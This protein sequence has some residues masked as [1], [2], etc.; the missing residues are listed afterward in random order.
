MVEGEVDGL[1]ADGFAAAAQNAKDGCPVSKALAG[2]T[3]T[4]EATRVTAIGARG[5]D[6]DT[7]HCPGPT[8]TTRSRATGVPYC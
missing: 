2:T 1:D 4:L 3:I 6:A 5:S 7:R 8:S